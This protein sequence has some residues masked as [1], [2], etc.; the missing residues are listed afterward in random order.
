[1]EVYLDDYDVPAITQVIWD[2]FSL[3]ANRPDAVRPSTYFALLTDPREHYESVMKL[4]FERCRKEELIPDS[5]PHMILA[6]R[7]IVLKVYH[8]ALNM[9]LVLPSRLDQAYDWSSRTLHFHYTSEGIQFFRNRY[10]SISQPGFLAKRLKELQEKYPSI[11]DGQV[12][13][14]LEAH[15]CLLSECFRAAIVV[16]GVANEDMC[17]NLVDAV[18]ANVPAPG[19]GSTLLQD[20]KNCSDQNLEFTRRWKPAIRILE[21]LKKELRRVGKSQEWWPWWEMVPG[22]LF[23]VGEAVRLARNAAAH[24]TD[25]TFTKAEVLL[26]LAAMPTQLEMI[27]NLTD[28]LTSPPIELRPLHGKCVK[29]RI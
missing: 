29:K 6:A 14:L 24:S 17:L 15:R 25:R 10:F 7:H 16:M 23:T 22:S 20:W 8:Q 21:A 9:G 13:L 26:L 11:E 28:F 27:A 3:L 19:G 5:Q 12:E 18:P 2:V 4:V 1:M